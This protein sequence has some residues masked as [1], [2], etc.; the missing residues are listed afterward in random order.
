MKILLNNAVTLCVGLSQSRDP[1]GSTS[2]KKHYAFTLFQCG[3]IVVLFSARDC[4]TLAL[5]VPAS[6]S[7]HCIVVSL[8]HK[9]DTILDPGVV[10]NCIVLIQHHRSNKWVT[11]AMLPVCVAHAVCRLER[12]I[13]PLLLLLLLMLEIT[14]INYSVLFNAYICMHFVSYW[15]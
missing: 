8:S 7:S 15:S 10:G 3:D 2:Q 1:H 9:C 14:N 4:N 11:Y 13:Y 5:W 12:L 6:C